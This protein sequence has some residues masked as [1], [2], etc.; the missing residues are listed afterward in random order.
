MKCEYVGCSENTFD[1]SNYCI[2][3]IVLP[4]NENSAEFQRIRK[5][6]DKKVEEKKSLNE[7]NFKGANLF[8]VDLNGIKTDKDVIFAH[9]S[10]LKS[11]ECNH[12]LIKGDL[13]FDEVKIEEHCS[14]EF[15]QIEG[16]VSFYMGEIQGNIHFDKSK[17]GKYAWFEKFTVHGEASFNH[18]QIGSSVSFKRA[19]IKENISFYGAQ[20]GGNA[21]FNHA[22][23]GGDAWFDLVEIKGGLNFKNTIFKDLKGKERA[24]RSAKIIWERL[25]DRERADY[26]FYHEME[27]KRKQ[28][29]WYLRYPELIAQYPFGYGVH[30]SRLLFT[31]LGVL[32][33]FGFIYW[34]IE[35]TFSGNALLEKLRFSFLTL[36]IPAYGVISAKAGVMGIITIIEAFIGAFTW[37][38]F[39]VTFAR[40][41]MR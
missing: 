28:K 22:K 14:L 32:I 8:S 21:W 17:I 26:H 11:F 3:H 30:P 6:K 4:S 41:Y 29:K 23:I 35:G 16:T 9:A 18:T 13:W 31:F 1:D 20:I 12:A 10:I 37:P 7:F 27:A 39:I 15:S 33:I 34:I 36:I 38:T 25:G 5:L 40:K 19:E 24:F 2:L